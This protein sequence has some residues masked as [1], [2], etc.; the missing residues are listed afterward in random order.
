MNR[1]YRPPCSAKTS[2]NAGFGVV[3]H[4]FCH[5]YSMTDRSETWTTLV[6]HVSMITAIKT[7]TSP[8]DSKKNQAELLVFRR[9]SLIEVGFFGISQLFLIQSMF[10]APFPV[11]YSRAHRLKVQYPYLPRIP[12]TDGHLNLIFYRK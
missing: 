1:S 4:G 7:V 8:G 5:N 11:P 2:E 9:I 3:F 6:P 10:M 12:L